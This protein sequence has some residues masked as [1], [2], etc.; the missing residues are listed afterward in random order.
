MTLI[1]MLGSLLLLSCT[2]NKKEG[3]HMAAKYQ[4]PAEDTKHEGTWLTWPHKYTYGKSYQKELEPIWIAMVKALHTGEKVHIIAY[5]EKEQEHITAL[6][7]DPQLDMTKVDFVISKSD[8]VWTRDT[9]PMFVYDKDKKPI[10]ADFAFDGWGEKTSFKHDDQIPQEVAKAKKLPIISIPNLV[11]EGGAVELDGSGTLMACKSSVISKNRN[12]ELTQAQVESLAR[13]YLGVTNF[14]WLEGVMDQDITDAHIDGIARFYDDQTILTVSEDDFFELYED[15]SIDDYNALTSA[16]NASGSPY[17][18]IELPLTAKN[19]EGLD[20][21]GSYLNFYIGNKVVL[22]P[23]YDDVN[24]DKAIELLSTLYEDK[25][26]IPINVN[27]LYQYG[28][29]LHCVTQQQP[30]S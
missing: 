25:E 27:A 29:M 1:L 8:D 17:E 22:L 12:Q 21:K 14:I 4:F 28:G 16:R 19:V 10:I 18:I 20:Y 6:L 24:D 13:T 2:T 30:S 15:I 23:V 3:E 26:I 11:L 7:K 9:G 5:N